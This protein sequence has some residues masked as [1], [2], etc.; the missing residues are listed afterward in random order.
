M[1]RLVAVAGPLPVT[2]HRAF[3]E[4]EDSMAALD[5]LVELK[6]ARVLTSGGAAR[7]LD[8]AARLSELVARSAGRVT[9]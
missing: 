2:F 3:D 6:V 5:T 1:E 7:A 4:V 9:V 8:G